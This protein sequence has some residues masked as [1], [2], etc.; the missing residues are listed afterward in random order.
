MNDTNFANSSGI[1]D[2]NNYSTVKDIL[3]MSNYLIKNYPKY[4]DYFKETSFTWN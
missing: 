3:I 2:V 4:Y 1:N